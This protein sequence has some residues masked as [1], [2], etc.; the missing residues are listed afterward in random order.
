MG[1]KAYWEMVWKGGGGKGWQVFLLQVRLLRRRRRGNE[2]W[3]KGGGGFERS[4]VGRGGTKEEEVE[5]EGWVARHL[6]KTNSQK[7]QKLLF[8]RSSAQNDSQHPRSQ[9]L[10][11]HTFFFLYWELLLPPPLPPLLLCVLVMFLCPLLYYYA[12][13]CGLEKESLWVWFVLC[14][15]GKSFLSPFGARRQKNAHKSAKIGKWS[16]DF[17]KWRRGGAEAS[18]NWKESQSPLRPPP[19]LSSS[20]PRE[21]SRLSLSSPNLI[22]F[23]RVGRAS[24]YARKG[25]FGGVEE[26]GNF[27]KKRHYYRHE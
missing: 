20:P 22:F 26:T 5:E 8:G 7:T 23:S 10:S 17:M 19:F 9:T 6:R 24:R 12:L 18:K 15:G 13:E 2:G 27:W 3:E 21:E 14:V 1:H 16:D 4:F 11:V 25:I